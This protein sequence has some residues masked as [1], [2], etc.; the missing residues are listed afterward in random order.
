MPPKIFS[1]FLG[2]N[3]MNFAIYKYNGP[4]SLNNMLSKLNGIG[5]MSSVEQC[6]YVMV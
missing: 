6:H 3:V 1:F 2:K 5:N 4:M